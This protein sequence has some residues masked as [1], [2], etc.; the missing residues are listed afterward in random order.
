M[1]EEEFDLSRLTNCE[2]ALW[3]RYFA[4]DDDPNDPLALRLWAFGHACI[5]ECVGPPA[6]VTEKLAELAPENQILQY[7]ENVRRARERGEITP[8]STR[9]DWRRGG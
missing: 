3:E 5:L 8:I 4:D 1:A 2:R 6:V 9:S 7:V